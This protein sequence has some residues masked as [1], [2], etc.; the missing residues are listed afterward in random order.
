[1]APTINLQ[2]LPE[3]DDPVLDYIPSGRGG[4]RPGA[5]RPKGRKN[6]A[7]VARD[8]E[9]KAAEAIMEYQQARAMRENYEA[10]LSELE[11]KVK[12]GVLLDA[13]T[14]RKETF[15]IA[16][17][18]RDALLGIPDRIAPILAGE[19]DPKIVHSLLMAEIRQ[20]CEEL[21]GGRGNQPLQ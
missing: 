8:P 1:M 11:Y 4:R 15:A 20:V 16:R 19:D 21:S 17:K 18:A 9:G 5:G 2:A 14:V 13:D 3:S 7:T 6:K 12:S 10:L